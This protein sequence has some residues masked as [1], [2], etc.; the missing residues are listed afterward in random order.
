MSGVSCV[1]LYLTPPSARVGK[2]DDLVANVTS[3]L[4]LSA[5]S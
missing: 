2:Y 3:H 5:G 1:V 4:D